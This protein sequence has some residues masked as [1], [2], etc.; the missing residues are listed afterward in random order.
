MTNHRESSRRRGN[1][2][3]LVDKEEERI[4]QA[5]GTMCVQ[6]VSGNTAVCSAGDMVGSCGSSSPSSPASF[7][8][9]QAP[10]CMKKG[11]RQPGRGGG[12]QCHAQEVGM[13]SVGNAEPLKGVKQRCDV[14][15]F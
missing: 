14:A 12:S 3:V 4:F 10:G 9:P 15:R 13:H 7:F 2:L 5:T 11:G 8:P 1:I 6:R